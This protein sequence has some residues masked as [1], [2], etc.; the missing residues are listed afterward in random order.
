MVESL[1]TVQWLGLLSLPIRYEL[2]R[3][4]CLTVFYHQIEHVRSAVEQVLANF[5]PELRG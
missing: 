3:S 4:S 5:T 2:E 1:T